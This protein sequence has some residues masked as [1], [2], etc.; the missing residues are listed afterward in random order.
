[1][2]PWIENVELFMVFD[3]KHV[4]PRICLKLRDN[5]KIQHGVWQQF[6]LFF[7]VKLISC[8]LKTFYESINID[9]ESF[10]DG[11]FVRQLALEHM[12]KLLPLAV[13]MI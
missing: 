1:M 12:A 11:G 6:N 4:L 13:R 10:F 2:T 5:I 8:T 3:V 9:K 7:V